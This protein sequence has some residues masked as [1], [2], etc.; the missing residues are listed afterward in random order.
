MA[1]LLRQRLQAI[2]S[3][4]LP[5]KQDPLGNYPADQE[6]RTRAYL[7]LAHAEFEAALEE[8]CKNA[9][10][11]ARTRLSNNQPTRVAHA[12]AC[13]HPP[14]GDALP[15][16]FTG[17]TPEQQDATRFELRADSAIDAY[18]ESVQKNNGIKQ[19]NLIRL[20]VPLGINLSNLSATMLIECD[21]LGKTRGNVAH[22]KTQQVVDPFDEK[23]V[24]DAVESFIGQ[25]E[26]ML[27]SLA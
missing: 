12:M 3:A 22:G 25:L 18:L 13:F 20:L 16:K 4:L 23:R 21:K 1:N 9:A 10:L 7:V 17:M 5:A 24:V 27:A 26:T 14:P 8:A 19:F 6:Q 2:E 15:E 11:T